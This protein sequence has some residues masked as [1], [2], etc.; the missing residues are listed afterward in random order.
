[1][2]VL[3]TIFASAVAAIEQLLVVFASILGADEHNFG[4]PA[5]AYREV[6]LNG[7]VVLVSCHLYS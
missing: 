5:A 2:V 4:D 1:M 3:P 6:L 7:V